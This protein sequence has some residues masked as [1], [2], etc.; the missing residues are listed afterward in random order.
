[1][2]KDFFGQRMAAVSKNIL[3]ERQLTQPFGQTF[4]RHNQFIGNIIVIGVVKFLDV[5]PIVAIK[6]FA[7]VTILGKRFLNLGFGSFKIQINAELLHANACHDR[8]QNIAEL[9]RNPV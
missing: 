8:I 9:R 6:N 5:N 7:A 4:V 3:L 1:M 2:L